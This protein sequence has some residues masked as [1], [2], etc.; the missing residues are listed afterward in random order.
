MVPPDAERSIPSA[1]PYEFWMLAQAAM[2]FCGVGGMMFLIPAYVVAQG[3]SPA[4][5]GAVMA[6]A[7]ALAL[8]APFI[9][10]TADR[11]GVHRVFQIG[12]LALLVAAAISFAFAEQELLWLVAAALLG[13]GMAGLTVVNATFVV[14][15]GL[16]EPTQARKLSLLQLS[17]PTGQVLGLVVMAG[18]AAAEVS[19]RARFLVLAAVAA[20]FLAAVAL[21]NG[22]AA[23]RLTS[24]GP[25]PDVETVEPAAE[26]SDLRKVLLSQFGLTLALVVLVMASSQAIES[27]YPNYMREAFG[28]PAD[29]SAG[30]LAIIVLLS[31]PIYPL[32]AR[33]TAA[34]GPRTP[35]LVSAAVR[36]SAGLVLLLLPSDAGG[37]AVVVFGLVMLVYPLF[38]LNAA[39][40]AAV[41]SPIGAGAGQGAVGAAIA[42]G[43]IIAS[44]L[45]GWVA[46]E[47]GFSSLAAI[48]VAAA[49]SATA[50]GF[51]FLRPD[52]TSAD[53]GTAAGTAAQD[54]S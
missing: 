51:L 38:E 27:Q 26:G 28:L 3:G 52:T 50:I 49:G 37:A 19:F 48:T 21:T 42:L 2:G 13:V 22:A 33:W 31:I 47:V 7:G 9:G 36:A 34:A 10:N 1:G 5:A 11:F 6:L 41:T 53:A 18:L 16:D 14:G 32:A 12:G 24:Q 45:A 15:A 23:G 30:A 35:F 17:L 29:Q 46:G 20:L 40:L 8:A 54:S 44:V 43:T 4:D 25:G 39:T